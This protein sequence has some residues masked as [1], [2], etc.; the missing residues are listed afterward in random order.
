M[1][2]CHLQVLV[3][4]PIH[5]RPVSFSQSAIAWKCPSSAL[6]SVCKWLDP[7]SANGSMGESA[8]AGFPKL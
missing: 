5:C 6:T 8:G 3:V 7:A 1:P 4:G 2:L